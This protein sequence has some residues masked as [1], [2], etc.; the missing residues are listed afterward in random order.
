MF[1]AHIP[2]DR[3]FALAAGVPLPDRA[4][5]AALFADISGFTGLMERQVERAGRQGAEE[6][7]RILSR[8]FDALLRELHRCGGSV[9]GFAGDAMTCWLDDAGP[10]PEGLAALPSTSGSTRSRAPPSSAWPRATTW[11]VPGTS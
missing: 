7:A 3:R 11:R 8:V 5:G 4:D 6:V 9:I 1:D 10:G 2:M